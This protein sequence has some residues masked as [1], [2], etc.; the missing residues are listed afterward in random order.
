MWSISKQNSCQTKSSPSNCNNCNNF[1]YFL[2]TW[3]PLCVRV[4]HISCCEHSKIHQKGNF[5]FLVPSK[6][7]S[8]VILH[9]NLQWLML[10][11]SL[12]LTTPNSKLRPFSFSQPILV[13]YWVVFS[14]LTWYS[15]LKSVLTWQICFHSE[16]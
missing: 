9:M 4:Q 13:I 15:C 8:W 14:F 16:N 2:Q 5:I 11:Y 10:T 12:I 7:P 3:Q 6:N 1:Y